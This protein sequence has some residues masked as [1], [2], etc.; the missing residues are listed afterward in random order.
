MDNDSNEQ[1]AGTTTA[2]CAFIGDGLRCER[3]PHGGWIYCWSH[4]VEANARDRNRP[5]QASPKNSEN[6][7]PLVPT[8]LLEMAESQRDAMTACAE[9]AQRDL[10][11]ARIANEGLERLREAVVVEAREIAA[12]RD[13]MT[14]IA[15]RRQRVIEERDLENAAL[16]QALQMFRVWHDR[17]SDGYH[18]GGPV[19]CFCEPG[20]LLELG[21]GSVLHTDRCVRAT[22]ALAGE[23]SS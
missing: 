23:V 14:D 12:Q 16:R 18:P 17:K 20:R 19:P 5:F 4:L 10:T 1:R 6:R 2:A 8:A 22:K 21:D 3:S 7:G 11:S 13:A 9:Q 15:E